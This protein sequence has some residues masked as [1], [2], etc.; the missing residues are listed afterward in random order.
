[1]S[2]NIA[3]ILARA[4]LFDNLNDNQ[5]EL[6]ASIGEVVALGA[7][8]VL[9]AE[10]APSQE[11]YVILQGEV[12]ILLDP[13]LVDVEGSVESVV[14]A[15]L[16]AGQ[17]VGEIALVDQGVRSATARAGAGGAQLLRL[18]RERLMRLCDSYPE[19]G[20]RL[21]RNVA[22]DL[23]LKMR[24]ADLTMRRYQLML[25]RSARE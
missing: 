15:R 22:A 25:H 6:I 24:N 4:D 3:A 14:I 11:V 13:G 8:A 17:T 16:H 1:M 5:R 9:F 19:L 2:K 23:S 18:E 12:E 20:Y 10:N 7:G 21:M